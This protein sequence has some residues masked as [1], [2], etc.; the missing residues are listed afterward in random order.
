[1][2]PR[3]LGKYYHTHF[4]TWFQVEHS[5][6][7]DHLPVV[8]HKEGYSRGPSEITSI[9]KKSPQD[10][11]KLIEKDLLEGPHSKKPQQSLGTYIQTTAQVQILRHLLNLIS[12]SPWL[13]S[14]FSQTLDSVQENVP[15][16]DALTH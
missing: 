7:Y 5:R 11:L 1:M 4:H 3:I 12:L 2:F 16:Y 13:M 6:A 14:T 10:A 15:S 8:R 9:P